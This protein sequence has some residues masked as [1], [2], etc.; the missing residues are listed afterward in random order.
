MKL[1]SKLGDFAQREVL[2]R[3]LKAGS[4]QYEFGY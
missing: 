4:N 2:I 1:G 3:N